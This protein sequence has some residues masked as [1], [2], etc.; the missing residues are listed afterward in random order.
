MGAG[1]AGAL[2]DGVLYADPDVQSHGFPDPELDLDAH[3]V[4]NGN[5]NA[6]AHSHGYALRLSGV[7]LHSHRD[8]DLHSDLFTYKSPS[9]DVIR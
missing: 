5:F 2:A 1:V 7:N 3:P 6:H 4:F 9:V 8:L